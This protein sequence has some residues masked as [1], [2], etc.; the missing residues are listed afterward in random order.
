M[1]DARRHLPGAGV[2]DTK[3]SVIPFPRHRL[4]PTRP[5][6]PYVRRSAQVRSETPKTLP[7]SATYASKGV[8]PPSPVAC[9]TLSENTSDGPFATEAAAFGVVGAMGLTALRGSLTWRTFIDSLMGTMCTSCMV[10]LILAGAAFL[11][12]SMGFTGLPE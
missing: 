8:V 7:F 2:K 1:P 3:G 12:L 6:L 10:A 11:S 5:P 4:P 9:S